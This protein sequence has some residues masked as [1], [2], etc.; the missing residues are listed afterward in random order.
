MA[1]RN[2]QGMASVTTEPEAELIYARFDG[3]GGCFVEL[4]DSR[5]AFASGDFYASEAPEIRLRRPG[6]RWHLAKV[7]FEQYWLRR[8]A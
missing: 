1:G 8:W 4:G 2:D 6:R 3:R 7:A 5:A